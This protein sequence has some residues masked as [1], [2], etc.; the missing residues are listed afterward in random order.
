[1]SKGR[2]LHHERRANSRY[3]KSTTCSLN[4]VDVSEYKRVAVAFAGRV[5]IEQITVAGLPKNSSAAGRVG[6]EKAARASP[7]AVYRTSKRIEVLLGMND[8]DNIWQ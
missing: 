4:E 7:A 1:M 8:D 2:C 3:S 6:I 5:S